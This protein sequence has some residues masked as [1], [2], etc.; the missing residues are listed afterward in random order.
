MNTEIIKT[1]KEYDKYSDT[2]IYDDIC[3]RADQATKMAGDEKNDQYFLVQTLNSGTE[4]INPSKLSFMHIDAIIAAVST[5]V[6]KAVGITIK[7]DSKVGLIV[8][9]FSYNFLS[10]AFETT[11]E[12]CEFVIAIQNG[13]GND[14]LNVCVTETLSSEDVD[15]LLEV[16]DEKQANAVRR[17][18]RLQGT[19]L[20]ESM[21]F[22]GRI[23]PKLEGL[24]QYKQISLKDIFKEFFVRGPHDGP[25]RIAMRIVYDTLNDCYSCFVTLDG[26]V[27]R[28]EFCF[29]TL[30]EMK[31][32]LAAIKTNT[33]LLVRPEYSF[34]DSIEDSEVNRIGEV[35]GLNWVKHTFALRKQGTYPPKREIFFLVKQ[36]NGTFQPTSLETIL[37]KMSS[38]NDF[39]LSFDTTKNVY[40][41]TIERTFSGNKPVIVATKDIENMKYFIEMYRVFM[42]G[43]WDLHITIDDSIL[44][45]DLQKLQSDAIPQS[46]IDAELEA[47]ELRQPTETRQEKRAE[48]S[49]SSSIPDD[50]HSITFYSVTIVGKK[51]LLSFND[52]VSHFEEAKE[53][54]VKTC[55]C[56]ALKNNHFSCM[57]SRD[58]QPV[59]KSAIISMTSTNQVQTFLRKLRFSDY[60]KGTFI[61]FNFCGADESTVGLIEEIIIIKAGS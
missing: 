14:R 10:V 5:H 28:Y 50:P 18:R 44:S 9:A 2:S 54:T 38:V 47:R 55:L 21:F 43:R 12:M 7:R 45:A 61:T 1:E 20:P 49:S 40:M 36:E 57:I 29:K 15:A 25:P 35:I 19:P 51:S 58:S 13:F 6:G 31:T 4:G 27:D 16:M 17:I 32:F 3:S 24:S 41:C 60:L 52:I 33:P 48:P 23:D 39:S 37:N 8:A 11:S 30:T 59:S 53:L 42:D 56:D 22:K 46:R 34:D 26:K